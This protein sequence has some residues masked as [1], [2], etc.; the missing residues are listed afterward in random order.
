MATARGDLV[1]GEQKMVR[2]EEMVET[3]KRNQQSIN[4]TV[5]AHPNRTLLRGVPVNYTTGWKTPAAIVCLP[6]Q[7]PRGYLS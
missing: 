2:L 6:S 7:R 5:A 3:L 1:T 4:V